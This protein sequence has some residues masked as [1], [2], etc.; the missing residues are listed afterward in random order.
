MAFCNKC[1]KQL[2]GGAVFFFLQPPRAILSDINGDLIALY[3]VMRDNYLELAQAMSV[4]QKSHCREYYYTIRGTHIDDPVQ[5]ASRL[6]YLNRMC[7]N[8]MYR[9][10]KA[11]Q[12][13]VPIGT[14]HSCTYDIDYFAAYSE[15]LQNV[16]LE[17]IDFTATIDKA[18]E[19]DFIFAD[20]PYTISHNQNSFIKYNEQL[21]TWNDQYRLLES[22][23]AARSRGALIMATNANYDAIKKMYSDRGFY[24]K[25]IERFSVISSKVD[26][27][28]KQEELL[29]T[30]YPIN[31]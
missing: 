21:F 28:K 1:G 23:C 2:G 31:V 27:R 15:L 5:S 24:V 4:H 20:P 22:L 13:N 10:N 8:G 29:I 6:L 17:A 7:Y 26:K 30:S 12:F 25:V 3:Q 14:K 19:N 11:G 18:G 9:V 16:E